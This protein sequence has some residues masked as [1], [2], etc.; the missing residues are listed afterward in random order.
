MFRLKGLGLQAVM[1]QDDLCNDALRYQFLYTI[2]TKHAKHSSLLCHKYPLIKTY[3]N[4]TLCFNSRVKK[5]CAKLLGSSW[6]INMWQSKMAVTHRCR[7]NWLVRPL[8][9]K[10]RRMVPVVYPS[11][12]PRQGLTCAQGKLQK[13]HGNGTESKM[14]LY[15]SL[16]HVFPGETK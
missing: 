3:Q 2:H 9:T 7:R 10:R 12:L 8:P 13:I 1:V 6:G 5:R 14:W 4:Y 16:V 15:I 11:A